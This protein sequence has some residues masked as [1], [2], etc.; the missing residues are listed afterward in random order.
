[1]QSVTI[2]IVD[3]DEGHA[4][5]IEK[6]LRR[7]GVS[8]PVERF[9]NGRIFWEHLNSEEG[10]SR[11]YLALLDLNMPEL[12][13]YEVLK[14]MK[15]D[16]RFRSIPVI[17]LTTTDDASEINRCYEAGCNVYITKPVDVDRL[18]SVVDRG[19]ERSNLMREMRLLRRE[20]SHD[21]R[22]G[23]MVGGSAA[24]LQCYQLIEQVAPTNASVLIT[25][26]SGT[27]KELVARTVHRQSPRAHGPFVALNCSAIPESLLESELFGHEKGAFTGA[28]GA[29][30]GCFELASG[31][32]LF[33][34]EVGEMPL[35]LQKRLLRVLEDRRVRR[36]G[37]QV[38]IEVD[39]RVVSATNADL[40]LL[41]KRGDFREDFFYRLNV[42]TIDMP[43]L[44]ERPE[45]IPLLAHQF[46]KQLAQANKKSIVGFSS[47]ALDLLTHHD[48]P[49][50][51]RELRNAVE[52]AV[53]VCLGNEIE[54]HH[55]PSQLRRP[56]APQ[57]QNGVV[58]PHDASLEEAERLLIL[59]ALSVHEGNKT[60][61]AKALGITT[62]TLHM[63][64]KRYEQG[65]VA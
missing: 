11:Q 50:N 35:N 43:P 46:L 10:L 64:L 58:V 37:G 47:E 38:E 8:N 56:R 12:D 7:S 32:T 5:L 39:V 9:A 31:G 48:W 45:D 34:D 13:G 65:G 44:R 30:S 15:A 4:R 42:F 28:T 59:N 61:A 52:R 36:L 49:G 53:V 23:N 33:L 21:G 60:Q 17:I 16:E 41:L 3:D 22:F 14:R 62:K 29:R 57:A 6:N 25:G 1:M 54:S 27:G 26:E 2:A 63:K 55:L 51:A 18:R 19:L 40:Q 20:L 24:M